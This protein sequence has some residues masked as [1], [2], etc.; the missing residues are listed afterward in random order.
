MI[1]DFL[2]IIDKMLKQSAK[3]EVTY[4]ESK[5][6]KECLLLLEDG[7]KITDYKSVPKTF[8]LEVFFSRN[9]QTKSIILTLQEQKLWMTILEKRREINKNVK[10]I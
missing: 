3:N 7:W 2:K 4:I 1:D 9:S 6:I 8:N 5:S 10:S